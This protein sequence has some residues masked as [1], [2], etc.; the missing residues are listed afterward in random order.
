MGI[1]QL[2]NKLLFKCKMHA[3]EI[4]TGLIVGGVAAG[5]ALTWRAAVKTKD[6]IDEKNKK[7]SEIDK[8]VEAEEITAEDAE[9]QKK[10]I[11]KHS[12]WQIV[13]V[14]AAPG[15]VVVGTIALTIENTHSM[16]KDIS[17]AT[18]A[19][20]GLGALFE[21]YRERVIQDQ[22][23]EKDAQYRYG[24][25]PVEIKTTDE[26][27]NE[28]TATVQVDPEEIKPYD[29]SIWLDCTNWPLWTDD[30][31]SNMKVIKLIEDMCSD[32]YR[33]RETHWYLNDTCR[34]LEAPLKS[35]GWKVGNLFDPMDP[36]RDCYIKFRV[37]KIYHQN[38]DGTSDKKMV[39]AYII[40]PNVEGPINEELKKLGLMGD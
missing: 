18:A 5:T 15:G 19:A 29:Y 40:E 12:V 10:D 21:K 28:I 14:C 20:A 3:P 34:K 31:E 4:K 36:N 26:D 8:K 22:G 35:E 11:R 30:D 38:L 17:S 23:E 6:I 27:G 33:T 32:E 25:K 7:L 24:S 9:A 1:K 2:L 39:Y 13:K 16:K 37:T